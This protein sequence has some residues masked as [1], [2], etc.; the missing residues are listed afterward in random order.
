LLDL[1]PQFGVP[2]NAKLLNV[3]DAAVNLGELLG[4]RAADGID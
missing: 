4:Y 1:L 2:R 3:S